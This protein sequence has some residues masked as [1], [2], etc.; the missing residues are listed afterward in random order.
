MRDKL[1]IRARLSLVLR[2]LSA[3]T[4]SV[5]VEP[6]Q[7]L[8]HTRSGECDRTICSSVVDIDRVAVGVNCV[9]ARKDDIVHVAVALVLSFWAKYPRITSSQT[10]VR[11]I[12]TE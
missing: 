11:L 7:E 9:A 10:L 6:F 3:F 2:P 5:S 12:D 4:S 1:G 8:T